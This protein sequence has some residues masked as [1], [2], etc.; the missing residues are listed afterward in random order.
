MSFNR[1]PYKA[2]LFKTINVDTSNW[3]EQHKFISTLP[4]NVNDFNEVHWL[5]LM[6]PNKDYQS[7]FDS[8]LAARRLLGRLELL[9]NYDGFTANINTNE[10]QTR[11]ENSNE[12]NP[13][14]GTALVKAFDQMDKDFGAITGQPSR[15][16]ALT[17]NPQ[18]AKTFFNIMMCVNAETVVKYGYTY[19]QTDGNNLSGLVS[20]FYPIFSGS[21]EE[22]EFK[23]Y[24]LIKKF[25]IDSSLYKFMDV[26]G[27][28]AV[29]TN[30]TWKGQPFVG[31]I[32]NGRMP[33]YNKNQDGLTPHFFSLF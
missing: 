6:F 3:P 16:R 5:G 19:S 33:I 17:D 15:V 24:T 25:W 21:N 8:F 13:L 23:I 29:D 12:I 2:R 20:Q 26:L 31:N 11:I 10:I 28:Y 4:N 30:S 27:D 7:K 18:M 32:V 22:K 1:N 9:A 14:A